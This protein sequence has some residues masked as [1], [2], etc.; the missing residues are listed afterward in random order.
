MAPPKVFASYSHDSEKHKGWVRKLC[1]KLREKSVDV[2]LD[3]WDLGP[4]DDRI[5]FMERGVKDSD[6]VLVVCTDAYVKKANARERGAGYEGYIITAELVDD[7]G[8]DKFIP[9]IR[10]S[11]DNEKT[12]IF[13]TPKVYIDFTDDDQFDASFDQLLR[14]I[15]GAPLYPKPP[16]GKNPFSKQLSEPEASNRHHPDV[17]EKLEFASQM[18]REAIELTR[19]D[20]T[21][22]WQQLVK[23]IRR[24]ISNSLREWKPSFEQQERDT[25][26]KILETVDK[27]VDIVSPLISVALAGVESGKRDF[28]DQ[29]S[30]LHDLFTI[31]EWKDSTYTTWI[32]MPNVLRY[33]YHSLHGVF[34]LST[35][36]LNLALSLVRENVRVI[37]PESQGRRRVWETPQLTGYYYFNAGAIDLWKHL[38]DAHEKW[39]WLTY[40]FTDDREK[41]AATLVAYYMALN[42]HELA[43]IIAAGEESKLDTHNLN[44]PLAFL[45]EK[46]ER[47]GRAIDILLHNSALPELWMCLGVKPEQMKKLW[48]D[49]INR[50]KRQF[51]NAYA[52]QYRNGGI[53]LDHENF[54][55]NL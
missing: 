41:Y 51:V 35:D 53:H 45:S 55:D 29:K 50:C 11:S 15:H 31:V 2:I 34:S 3:Q 26:A 18:Y 47:K 25:T 28:K 46:Y 4:G 22:G 10:E 39:K 49:W 20:D 14:E 6:R 17:S 33:V 32:D 1:T 38:V 9:I 7:L 21:V 48:G 37:Y 44:I 24:D 23:Q 16:L 8:T 5:L 43:S 19:E 42:I 30:V 54:F 36:Q 52:G 27:A 40:I 12:P 13:L